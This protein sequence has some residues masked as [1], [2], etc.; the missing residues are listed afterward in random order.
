MLE[1]DIEKHFVKVVKE[2][3]GEAYKFTSP[4]HRGVSD[5]I[6]CL[7]DGSTWFIEIKTA[8]GKLAP[9]QVKFG[10]RMYELKQHYACFWSINEINQWRKDYELQLQK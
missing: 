2:M 1:K 5:R 8:K 9:L 6:V 4:S 3:G 10:L 7:P